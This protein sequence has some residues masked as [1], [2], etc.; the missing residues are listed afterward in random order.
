[1]YKEAIPAANNIYTF[2]PFTVLLYTQDQR[3]SRH[4]YSSNISNDNS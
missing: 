2:F 4:I 3:S 1:M